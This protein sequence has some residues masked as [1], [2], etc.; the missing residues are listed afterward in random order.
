MKTIDYR[1]RFAPSPTGKLHFGSLVAALASYLDAKSQC[2]EWLVRIENVDPPRE[3]P[4]SATDILATLEAFGFAWDGPVLYQSTRFERYR[5]IVEDLRRTGLAY[6]CACS[7]KEI[8]AIGRPGHEG[9]IYPGTCR[10]GLPPGREGI[11]L[12]L[13][14]D[15]SPI[16]F[17]DR[18]Q[19]P[20]RQC[21]QSE[22]G[23]FIVFRADGYFPYQLAVVVDDQDQ[24]ITHIVRGC[25]LLT[26]TPRQI[27]LQRQLDFATP[28][29]AHF[30]VALDVT[31]HK[32]S[33]QD[34]AHPIDPTN[35]LQALIQAWR[36]LGQTDPV[37]EMDSLSG[38]W[39]WALDQWEIE[40]VP[41]AES[42]PAFE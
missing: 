26:S 18:I 41:K 36:F 19:G 39:A 34:L 5:E 22:I 28:S 20:I 17:D 7:R 13:R 24:G 15:D 32:L 10:H 27:H 33:K 4:G 40:K 37:P 8:A 1:G 42:R 16:H 29:Y 21:L 38:W 2:G 3:I 11:A 30:P 25:D 31:G 35:P 23:D 6:P 12:R 9:P 14:T